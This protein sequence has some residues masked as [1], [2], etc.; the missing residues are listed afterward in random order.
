MMIHATIN[1][2]H[3]S[4]HRFTRE[5]TSNATNIYVLINIAI[6]QNVLNLVSVTGIGTL[7]KIDRISAFNCEDLMEYINGSLLVFIVFLI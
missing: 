4:S 6:V 1:C 7:F 2:V 5:F 3:F